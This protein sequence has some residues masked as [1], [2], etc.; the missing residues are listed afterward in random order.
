MVVA[1]KQNPSA[2]LSPVLLNFASRYSKAERFLHFRSG[3]FDAN[4]WGELNSSRSVHLR[5]V[6]HF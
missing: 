1:P 5:Y 6:V 3:G 4:F 2:L